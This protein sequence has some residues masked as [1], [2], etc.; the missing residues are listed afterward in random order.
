MPVRKVSAMRKIHAEDRI[1]G[2][3]HR[4]KDAHVGLGSGVGL[5][6]GV[7]CPEELPR[8]ARDAFL[9]EC[10]RRGLPVTRT[11]MVTIN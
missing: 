8:V 7:V 1:T 10:G 3:E 9:G 6:V 2:L 11:E 5:H 4:K